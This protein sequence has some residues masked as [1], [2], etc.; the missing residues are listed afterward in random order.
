MPSSN[1][2]DMPVKIL[3]RSCQESFLSELNWPDDSVAADVAA[4]VES[5]SV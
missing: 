5:Q 4:D 3:D 2:V 1:V